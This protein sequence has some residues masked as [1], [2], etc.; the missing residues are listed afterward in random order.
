MKFFIGVLLV[1]G[2]GA[3]AGPIGGGLIIVALL[4]AEEVNNTKL[5][6]QREE[7]KEYEERLRAE[8]SEM[9][10]KEKI[11]EEIKIA[12]ENLKKA[13]HDNEINKKKK[14]SKNETIYMM[15]G[16]RHIFD[17]ENFIEIDSD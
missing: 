2:V 12:A 4:I 15:R 1:M 7:H 16:K 3:I 10:E 17:G 13:V 5:T 8:L 11:K 9:K 6:K 14:I